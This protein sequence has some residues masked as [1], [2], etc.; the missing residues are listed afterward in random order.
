[1]L[2]L[3]Q[4]IHLIEE[5]SFWHHWLYNLGNHISL[6]VVHGF[7]FCDLK[8]KELDVMFTT[9]IDLVLGMFL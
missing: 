6:D 7:M 3:L 1:M 8:I 4:I 5:L 9:T 2:V